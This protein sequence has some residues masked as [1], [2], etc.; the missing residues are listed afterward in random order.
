M[1][2]VAYICILIVDSP[3]VSERWLA[4]QIY[5]VR[6]KEM[7]TAVTDLPIHSSV[8]VLNVTDRF[9]AHPLAWDV[10]AIARVSFKHSNICVFISVVLNK[11]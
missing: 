2:L 3:T 10:E 9:P 7:Y 1:I 8:V 5:V 11:F 6:L 4:T